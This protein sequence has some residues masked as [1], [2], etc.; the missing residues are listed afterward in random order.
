[1]A[2]EIAAVV[3]KRASERASGGELALNRSIRFLPGQFCYLLLRVRPSRAGA[4]QKS[5][6]P[7]CGLGSKVGEGARAFVAAPHAKRQRSFF[8][9]GTGSSITGRES[10]PAA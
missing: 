6:P 1:V 9:A 2:N 10:R 5:T 8:A 7:A 3:A 4:M